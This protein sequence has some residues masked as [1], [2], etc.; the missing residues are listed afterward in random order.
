[1]VEAA[2]TQ[3]YEEV[4]K[5]RVYRLLKLKRT[6]LPSDS[7]MPRPYVPVSVSFTL[8]HEGPRPRVDVD[9]QLM[10]LKSRIAPSHIMRHTRFPTSRTKIPPRRVRIGPASYSSRFL[11]IESTRAQLR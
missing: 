3:P 11:G 5:S 2:T 9:K 4:L 7:D 10:G 1:M 8:Q 6:S